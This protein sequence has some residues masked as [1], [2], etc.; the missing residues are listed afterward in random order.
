MVPMFA[1]IHGFAVV[2]WLAT[3]PKSSIVSY[4]PEQKHPTSTTLETQSLDAMLILEQG[5]NF[6]IYVT[7]DAKS[8][9]TTLALTLD[10]ASSVR[11]W[12]KGFRLDAMLSAIQVL[13]WAKDA[14]SGQ[15]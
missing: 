2:L 15:M 8:E 14:M 5:A 12:A 9:S 10:F 7:M 1:V 6:R 11:F 4:Y 13:C 3:P